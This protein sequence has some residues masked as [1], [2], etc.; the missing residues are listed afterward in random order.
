MA[1]IHKNLEAKEKDFMELLVEERDSV[2]CFI[3]DSRSKEE[4]RHRYWKKNIHSYE[5]D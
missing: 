3:L 5:Y 1:D 4:H 2:E